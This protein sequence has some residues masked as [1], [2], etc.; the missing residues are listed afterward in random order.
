MRKY[1]YAIVS[2]FFIVFTLNLRAENRRHFIIL[3]D[4]SGSYWEKKNQAKI[5][6]IQ[7]SVIA[8]FNN[9]NVGNGLDLLSKEQSQHILFFDPQNDEISFLWFVADLA[10]NDQFQ[11][12]TNGEYQK[13]EEYFFT[14][15][16]KPQFSNSE[17]NQEAF[18]TE[19]FSNRPKLN[20][21]PH[22]YGKLDVYS[23]TS[24]AYPL[25]L[26][27]V[28]TD[29]SQEY[30]ILII[31]DFKTGSTFGNKKDE[32]LFEH[33]FGSAFKEKEDGVVSRVAFLK[34]QFI[35]L[36]FCDYYIGDICY[37]AYKIK[38]NAGYPKPENIDVRINSNIVFDQVSYNDDDYS[39][40]ESEI[41]FQHSKDLSIDE[42]GI[43]ILLSGGER[44]Y[45]D[46]SSFTH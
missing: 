10:G 25:C 37:Y 14:P 4:N 39:L 2:V 5:K 23:F 11:K 21:I 35:T 8:L 44:V 1:I 19:N 18:L 26:D 38:P 32:F 29:Y 36:D 45:K 20:S 30:I 46:I 9:E 7:D 3:Q 41:V 22:Y 34:G 27:V 40:R 33:A 12:N 43:E 17:Y 42:I 24:M 15:G 13:F 16:I 31:S 6:A 28:K